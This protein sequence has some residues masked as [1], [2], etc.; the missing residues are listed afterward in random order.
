MTILCQPADVPA[1][2]ISSIGTGVRSVDDLGAALLAL[3]EDPTE[4]LIV[5]GPAVEIGQ[6]LEFSARLRLERPA[7]NQLTAAARFCRT[8]DLAATPV[9]SAPRRTPS[10]RRPAHRAVSANARTNAPGQDLF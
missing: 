9:D 7:P 8:R 3:S 1:D 2:L 10:T 4:N 5:V 6:A